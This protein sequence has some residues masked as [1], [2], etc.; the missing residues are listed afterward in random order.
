MNF[1]G[2][3][4]GKNRSEVLDFSINI[5]PLGM[6]P[7]VVAALEEALADLVVYPE[8]DGAATKEK[9]AAALSISPA[10]MILGNGAIELIYLYCRS[11]RPRRATIIAPTFNEYRRALA[12]AGCTFIQDFLLS[13]AE[14]FTLDSERLAEVVKDQGIDTVFLCNPNNPT[15]KVLPP[16]EV[17][18]MIAAVGEAVSWFIDESFIEFSSVSSL[19]GEA[20]EREN[21]FVLHSL[22][23]FFAIPGL[24]IGCGIGG[25]ETTAQMEA[26]KE[27]WTINSLALVAGKQLYADEAFI[28]ETKAFIA[29]ERERVY[30]GLAEIPG[31]YPY[32]SGADF[33]LV[34]LEGISPRALNE[35]LEKRGIYLR[36][37]EDF[38]GLGADHV[39]IA[40]K[41]TADNDRLL[42]AL[43]QIMGETNG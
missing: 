32:K 2:G 14:G 16:E 36:L 23:K 24:R 29:K 42:A 18:A 11:L 7:R 27:P 38:P 13:P 20:A 4:Q 39:R 22:T 34:R 28:Q 41:K 15:G 37:C 6:P 1:H 10:Q 12:M 25:R 8:I 3:Y 40:V 26:R 17:L 21:I 19:K 30:A 35:A 33:H 9:L 43:R 31:L 5:N